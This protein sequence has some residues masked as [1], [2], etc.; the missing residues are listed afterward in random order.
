MTREHL[1]KWIACLLSV[2]TVLQLTVMQG[3]VLAT[4]VDNTTEEVIETTTEVATEEVTEATTE[5]ATEEVAETTTEA[6]AEEVTET[7]T[8]AT[9]EEVTETTTEAT[10]EEVTETTAEATTEEVTETTAEAA[11]EELDTDEDIYVEDENKDSEDSLI[12]TSSLVVDGYYADWKGYPI[13][14]ITYTSNNTESIHVGQIYT[15]GERV[16]VHF[17]MNDLY[18]N[19][20]MMQQMTIKINGSRYAIGLFPVNPDKSIDWGFDA[21]HLVEGIHTNYGLIVNY[22]QYCDSKAAITIYDATHQTNTPGDEVEFSFSLKDFARITGIQVDDVSEIAIYNPNI[23]REGVK[24]VGTSTGPLVG[25]VSMAMIA[26]A[27][28]LRQKKRKED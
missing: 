20:I 27:G 3:V 14:E 8:E 6:T 13:T 5:A 7:T 28:V 16:Y 24:W 26:S 19:Q 2:A 12:V 15:D 1:K 9:T 22:T 23:G 10:T 25:V 4:S 11:T 17:R 21:Y 18:E